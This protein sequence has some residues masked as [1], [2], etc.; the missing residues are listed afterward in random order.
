MQRERGGKKKLV[1]PLGPNEIQATK[2]NWIANLNLMIFYFPL[3][4]ATCLDN[5]VMPL[6]YSQEWC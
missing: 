3:V 6:H 1:E 4:F 2:Q 5:V